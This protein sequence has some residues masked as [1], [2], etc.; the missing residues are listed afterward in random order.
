MILKLSTEGKEWI[1]WACS[2]VVY[3]IG[4]GVGRCK[5]S[6]P[7]DVLKMILVSLLELFYKLKVLDV[8]KNS[9]SRV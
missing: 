9:G 8:C 7:Y 2:R 1:G 3:T 6:F 5:L 4:H